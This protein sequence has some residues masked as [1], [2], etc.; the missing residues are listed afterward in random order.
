MIVHLKSRPLTTRLQHFK[1]VAHLKIQLHLKS[2]IPGSLLEKSF[3]SI[4]RIADV[5]WEEKKIVFEIQC[6]PISKEEVQSRCQD[7]ESLGYTPV[8]ILY[9]QRFNRKK[10]SETE[11]FLRKR[12][13]FFADGFKIYDQFEVIQGRK[14]LF[15]G[16]PLPV[17]LHKPLLPA[18]SL[19]NPILA[20]S[21]RSWPISFEGDLLDRVSKG[22]LEDLKSLEF[23]FQKKLK[24]PLW[25]RF[26][27]E[28]LYF[29]LS[30]LSD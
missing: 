26:Y 14:R 5:V 12:V 28:W 30:R 2:L 25:K 6:S 27:K 9:S 15:R 16:L 22:E 11:K 17:E 4:G 10:L 20:I 7:Y 23:H 18:L 19:E 1:S 8:W 21:E 13:C 24:N 29:L 3:P